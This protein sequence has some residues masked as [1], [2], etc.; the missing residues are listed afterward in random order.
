MKLNLKKSLILI[1]CTTILFLS[2]LNSACNKAE[3]IFIPINDT[4]YSINAITTS[5]KWTFETQD[6]VYSTPVIADLDGDGQQEIVF[7][8]QDNTVYCIDGEKKE[9]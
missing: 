1:F 2:G 8:C 9:C 4:E 7:G 6:H 3:S 5:V